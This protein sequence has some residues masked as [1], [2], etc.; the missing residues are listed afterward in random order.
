MIKTYKVCILG[1]GAFGT[2]LAFT[3]AHNKYIKNVYIYARSQEVVDS[4]NKDKVNPKFLS[5]YKLPDNIIA[6]SNVEE[7]VKGFLVLCITFNR[8]CLYA[9]LYSYIS[10]S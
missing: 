5:Q 6:T 4:I 3:A 2:A 8:C 7:A 1:A 10:T 9:L